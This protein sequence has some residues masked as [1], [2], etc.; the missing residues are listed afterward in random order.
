[1]SKFLPSFAALAL[2]VIVAGCKQNTDSSSMDSM[3][4]KGDKTMAPATMPAS[5]PADMK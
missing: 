2:L 1:M 5:M 4:M 3:N